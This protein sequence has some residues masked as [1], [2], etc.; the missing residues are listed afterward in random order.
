MKNFV[1]AVTSKFTAI[2]A[3]AF[4]FI[5]A[6]TPA[7]AG[8]ILTDVGTTIGTGATLAVQLISVGVAIGAGYVIVTA[9]IDVSRGRK[10]WGEVAGSIIGAGIV[11]LI[12]GLFAASADTFIAL[13]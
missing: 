5:A 1:N 13:L 3:L 6:T 2:V 10:P 9:L 4:T 12:V 7:M 8:T 11:A